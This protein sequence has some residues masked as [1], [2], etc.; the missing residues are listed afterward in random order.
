[1]DNVSKWSVEREEQLIEL[2]QERPCLCDIGS[3][4]YANRMAKRK[5]IDEIADK[6]STSGMEIAFNFMFALH[7]YSSSECFRVK[8]SVVTIVLFNIY[9]HYL[10]NS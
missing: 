1:M 6:L 9:L 8:T 3:K 4:D 10:N 7:L 5:A 2:W